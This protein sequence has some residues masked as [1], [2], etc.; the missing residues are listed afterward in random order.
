[1]MSRSP[2]L[3]VVSHDTSRDL[4]SAVPTLITPRV[5][6]NAS[7]ISCTEPQR[8]FLT[9]NT[10]TLTRKKLILIQPLPELSVFTTSATRNGTK[11]IMMLA[12]ALTP[13]QVSGI[14][15]IYIRIKYDPVSIPCESCRSTDYGN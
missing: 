15:E 3:P 5:I 7:V 4:C 12:D 8:V 1:R 10:W 6:V 2:R 14:A 9:V 13:F 11:P